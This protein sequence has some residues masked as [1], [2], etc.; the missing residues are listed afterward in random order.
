[1]F[2]F[3]KFAGSKNEFL[4]GYLRYKTTFGHKVAPDV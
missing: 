4:K 2:I 1:M 3:S